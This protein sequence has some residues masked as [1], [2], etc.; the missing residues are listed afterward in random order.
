MTPQSHEWRPPWPATPEWLMQDLWRT[1]RDLSNEMAGL[2]PLL[3]EREKA[4]AARLDK[5]EACVKRTAEK[6]SALEA[7]RKESELA[8][9]K[10][11]HRLFALACVGLSLAG[12]LSA[13]QIKK[14]LDLIGK[15]TE[16]L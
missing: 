15:L 12:H 4:I 7:A 9:D 14:L 16:L 2:K 11:K 13:D 5:I 3:I 8:R 10:L 6:A 1:L